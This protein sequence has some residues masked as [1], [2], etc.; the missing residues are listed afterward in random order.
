MTLSMLILALGVLVSVA[1]RPTAGPETSPGTLVVTQVPVQAEPAPPGARLDPDRRYP[2]GSRI[3]VV[4][5]TGRPGPVRVLS[6]GLARAGAP[7]L[8]L[9]GRRVVFAGSRSPE[10][11]WT[12][13]EAGI[14]RRRPVQILR[15]EKDC[16]DP[17]YLPRGRIIFTC[18][19]RGPEPRTWSLYTATLGGRDLTRITFGPG[20]AFDPTPLADGRI[21][22]A[23]LQRPGAGRPAAASALFTI[24][25]DGTL[26]APFAGSH[27][28]PAWKVRP[29]QTQA[30]GVI[31]VTAAGT[32]GSGRLER[33]SMSRPLATRT[34]LVATGVLSAEPAAAGGL[35]VAARREADAAGGSA[36]FRLS[37]GSAAVL[38]PLLDDPAYHEVEGLMAGTAMR[39]PARPSAV[40]LAARTGTLVCYDA[41]LT[42]GRYGGPGGKPLRL[43]AEMLPSRD[44]GDASVP[45]GEIPMAADGSFHIQVLADRAL[46]IT[47]EHQDGRRETSGWF[48]VRPGEVRSCFGCHENR[49]S[50]PPNRRVQAVAATA[51]PL[52]GSGTGTPGAAP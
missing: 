32:A 37:P 12:L 3:V 22:F 51:V 31:F 45:L 36:L 41:G 21:L 52:T 27:T 1:T 39:V 2:A 47:A 50:A 25:P 29:R 40:D 19:G 8:S 34:T 14:S 44:G 5:N 10:L 13:F 30:G 17:A 35:L 16:T 48:W 4:P 26:L 18:A 7:D 6:R 42:D 11:G 49:E 46:R 38:E 9:D 43:T 33:V 23:M 15:I 20:S 28:G 24:N